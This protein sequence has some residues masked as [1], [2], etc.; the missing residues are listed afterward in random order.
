MESIVLWACGLNERLHTV[1]T[2]A[3]NVITDWWLECGG[4]SV[5]E[6]KEKVG[7]GAGETMA[8]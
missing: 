5:E 7:E 8:D 6:E 2:S 4:W 3:V 1:R